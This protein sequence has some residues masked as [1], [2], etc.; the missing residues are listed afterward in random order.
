MHTAV[1]TPSKMKS[2]TVLPVIRTKKKKAQAVEHICSEQSQVHRCK[3][4]PTFA[5]F[6]TEL[7]VQHRTSPEI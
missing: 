5:S 4:W 6:D 7:A 1:A 2:L 3:I